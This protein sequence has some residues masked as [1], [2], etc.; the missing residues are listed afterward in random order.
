MAPCTVLRMK[1]ET[2]LFLGLYKILSSFKNL[3]KH[4]PPKEAS[5]KLFL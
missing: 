1:S 4:V 3:T 5:V 2:Y